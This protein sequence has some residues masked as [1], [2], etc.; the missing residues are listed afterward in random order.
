MIKSSIAVKVIPIL[1][2]AIYLTVPYKLVQIICFAVLLTELL[3]FLYALILS[4]KIQIERNLSTMRLHSGE[5]AE[6]TFSIINYS[7]LPVFV[8]YVYDD[9]SYIYVYDNGNRKLILLRPK[10]IKKISYRIHV[11]QRGEF[12]AGPVTLSFQIH[13]IFFL[14]QKKLIQK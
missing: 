5:Q 9:I 6:I 4:K 2:L 11:Q 14:S 13:L 3:C 8:C 7:R 1:S 10:E 12:Y